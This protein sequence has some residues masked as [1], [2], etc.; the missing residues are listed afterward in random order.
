MQQAFRLFWLRETGCDAGTLLRAGE[1]EPEI[2]EHVLALAQGAGDE[3]ILRLPFFDKI[4]WPHRGEL[5]ARLLWERRGNE[6]FPALSPNAALRNRAA[7]LALTHPAW[8]CTLH[9]R[10]LEYFR[11]WQRVSLALQPSFR[12]WTAQAYFQDLA[13][14]E[15]RDSAYSVLL[16]EAARVWR[17][18]PRGEF[19]YDFRDFPERDRA[20]TLALKMTGRNLQTVLTRVERQLREAGLPNLANRYAPVWAEDIVRLVRKN[21]RTF[22]KFLTHECTLINAIVGLG[23][24]RTAAGVNQF[25]RTASIALRSVCKTDLRPLGLRALDLTTEV[26]QSWRD[27]MVEESSVDETLEPPGLQST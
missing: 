24:N 7:H 5:L 26:L 4:E 19:T 6:I 13:R 1:L 16:Y 25:T 21:P 22:V 15:D 20:L 17:G 27:G 2:R 8:Q 9:P 14:F 12:A 18:R 23:S 11:K 10:G 3:I